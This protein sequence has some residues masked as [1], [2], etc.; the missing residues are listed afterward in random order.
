MLTGKLVRVR[1]AKNKLVPLYVEPSDRGLL[2]LAEQFLLVYRGAA[3]RTRGEI[4]EDL[5]DYIPEGPRGLLPGGLAKVLEDRCEF[6]VEA[7][8]PP[9]E[10]REAVFKAAATARA[11]AANA[12]V[13]FNRNEVLKDVAESLSLTL[14]P[15]QLDRSLFADLKDEQRV[16]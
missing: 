14:T 8:H 9:E 11:D 12:G 3:G 7:E 4:A 16:Q 1:F 15:E 13:P 2:A 5:A 10:L 6:E